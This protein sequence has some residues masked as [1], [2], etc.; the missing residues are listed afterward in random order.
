MFADLRKS[1]TFIAIAPFFQIDNAPS[2]VIAC[3]H[4]VYHPYGLLKC[5]FD[6]F[7]LVVYDFQILE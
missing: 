4:S 6:G 3:K 1:A 7:I 2:L 5:Y